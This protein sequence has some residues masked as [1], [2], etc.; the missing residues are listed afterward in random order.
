MGGLHCPALIAM[1]RRRS[2]AAAPK[3]RVISCGVALIVG[4]G[5]RLY[6]EKSTRFVAVA[7][8][9]WRLRSPRSGRS[10]QPGGQA[11]MKMHNSEPPADVASWVINLQNHQTLAVSLPRNTRLVVTAGAVQ[12][13]FAEPTLDWLG[14][15]AP[16]HTVELHEGGTYFVE[17]R[18]YT[19]MTGASSSDAAIYIEVVAATP[20]VKQ[21][22]QWFARF[23]DENAQ[24][25][26]RPGERGRHA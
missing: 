7:T 2:P 3:I 22:Y 16:L 6:W 18:Q 17:Q 8:R 5:R 1:I 20:I 13:T 21:L 14:Q 9:P 12:L 11:D 25:C 23:S 4:A 15:A 26:N 19:S 10:R 24:P